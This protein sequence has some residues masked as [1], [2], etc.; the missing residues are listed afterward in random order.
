MK[1]EVGYC[2]SSKTWD[3]NGE[4][5]THRDFG[6]EEGKKELA[7]KEAGEGNPNEVENRIFKLLGKMLMATHISTCTNVNHLFWPFCRKVSH[8]NFL[9][10]EPKKEINWTEWLVRTD[11]RV[12]RGIGVWDHHE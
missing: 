10:R 6:T 1:Q 5:I 11:D 8:T 7:V 4:L 2:R 12:A 3:S 9:K